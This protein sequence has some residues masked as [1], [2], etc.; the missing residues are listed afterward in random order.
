MYKYGKI[1]K[2]NIFA[3]T[4]FFLHIICLESKNANTC[5]TFRLIS[6]YLK[7]R[8]QKNLNKRM[9]FLVSIFINFKVFFSN[10]LINLNIR[11]SFKFSKF[12]QFIFL[13][14]PFMSFKVKV[15]CQRLIILNSRII[16][17]AKKN[18]IKIMHIFQNSLRV[19]LRKNVKKLQE[20]YMRD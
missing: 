15:L 4:M 20:M 11:N 16:L 3:N 9:Q 10:I 17:K 8:N 12:V 7:I 18:E 2:S 6:D 19:C 5:L 1:S 14:I 13:I